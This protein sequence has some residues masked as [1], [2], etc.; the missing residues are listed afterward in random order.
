[1][2]T[3]DTN[4]R[5]VWN[6][7]SIVVYVISYS[8]KTQTF[9]RPASKR[10]V[11]L[12]AAASKIGMPLT[13]CAGYNN[14]IDNVDLRIW[15]THKAALIRH[16]KSPQ[17]DAHCIILEDDAVWDLD[18]DD[19]DNV[20]REYLKHDFKIINLGGVPIGWTFPNPSI[21][22]TAMTMR[23]I[24]CHAVLYAPSFINEVAKDGV[25]YVPPHYGEGFAAL[26][27]GERLISSPPLAYQ[28]A[29]PSAQV[30][31]YPNIN[32]NISFQ[33]VCKWTFYSFSVIAPTLFLA[34]TIGAV[35]SGAYR[36]WILFTVLTAIALSLLI[37]LCIPFTDFL[38]TNYHDCAPQEQQQKFK[39]VMNNGVLAVKDF[40]P[41]MKQNDP[42][43]HENDTLRHRHCLSG[44]IG[45]RYRS[46]Y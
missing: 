7:G 17:R 9:R 22:H 29:W 14:S 11:E 25:M 5:R 1:M 26:Q 2:T 21:P 38:V 46:S 30:K 35:V 32:E 41:I 24:A 31:K 13:P 6:D 42:S 3:L 43:I 28:S 23:M 10:Y 39:A 20:L 18:A 19:L 12:E 16:S 36:Q 4:P 44:G 8:D 27:F 40:C 45:H 37:L 15:A 34:S 33:T